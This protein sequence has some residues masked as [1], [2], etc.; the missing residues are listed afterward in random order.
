MSWC[1]T[2]GTEEWSLA[3][4]GQTAVARAGELYQAKSGNPDL[5]FVMSHK[6]HSIPG[7]DV[8]ASAK[9]FV[10]SDLAF[11]AFLYA[12]DFSEKELRPLVEQANRQQPSAAA[13]AL[14]KLLG[15]PTLDAAL[16]TKAEL[17]QAQFNERLDHVAAA[18]TTLA[19][20][21]PV[22]A[23][24]YGPLLLAQMKG[25]PREKELKASLANGLKGKE[26]Q[27][28]LAAHAELAK[29]WTSLFGGGGNPGI[30]PDKKALATALAPLLPA[31][32]RAGVSLAEVIAAGK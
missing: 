6:G 22:L 24:Y 29:Q 26:A 14:A 9:C 5:R 16:K 7:S 28:A 4:L 30:V 2:I 31:T 25:D 10:F 13:I 21:D 12:P 18:I 1:I 19:A 23:V 20:E 27:S 8:T 11:G 17:L 32:S 15:K 3:N